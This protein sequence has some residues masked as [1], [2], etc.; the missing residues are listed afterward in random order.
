MLPLDIMHDGDYYDDADPKDPRE[1]N[2]PAARS[3]EHVRISMAIGR[4][5]IVE[6]STGEPVQFVVGAGRNHEQLMLHAEKIAGYWDTYFAQ[7]S[8]SKVYRTRIG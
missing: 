8:K 2:P 7:N 5:A 4:L 3:F 1:E 6:R